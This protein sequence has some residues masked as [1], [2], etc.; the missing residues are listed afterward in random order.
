MP[1]LPSLELATRIGF[2]ARGAMYVIIGYLALRFGRSESGSGA[3]EYIAEGSGRM[4]LGLMAL[5]FLA[6][7]VW[8]LSEA[9]IDTEGHGAEP[10]GMAARVGGGISGISHIGLAFLAA[11]LAFGQ[12]TSGSGPGAEQGAAAT[13]SLPGG[14]ALLMLAGAVLIGTGLWQILKAARADF[15]R[16]LSQDASRET[17]VVWL[18]RGGYA[19]RGIVFLITGWFA[20]QAGGSGNASEAGGMEKALN[21]LSP[22]LFA[23]VAFGLALFGSFS[24]V[25][26]RYRRINNPDVLAR[27]KGAARAAT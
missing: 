2:A 20:L 17:W 25:E 27:L 19:A 10:K 11:D 14:A 9:L 24:F 6:Y 26:A 21:S 4:L 16:H 1:S 22:S 12:K 18:G 8:R 3:L 13:L 7:G 23:V 5:G 15:L